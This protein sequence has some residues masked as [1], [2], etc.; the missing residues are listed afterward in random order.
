MSPVPLREQLQK[1]GAT[2]PLPPEP[3]GIQGKE[4]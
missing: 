1:D 3:S 2:I 4:S